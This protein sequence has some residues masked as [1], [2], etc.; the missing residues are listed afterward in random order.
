MRYNDFEHLAL[1]HG[2]T[3]AVGEVLDV[4]KHQA[5]AKK[6]FVV[7]SGPCGGGKSSF[8]RAGV[9][10]L[11][12][13]GG[14]PVGSGPWRHA[15]TRPGAADD[16]FEALAAALVAKS[17][18]PELQ[19]AGSPDDCRTLASQLRK[20]PNSV[21]VRIARVL[22]QLT[23]QELDRLSAKPKTR[24]LLPDKV[25]GPNSSGQVK[26]KL[27]LALVVDQLE[28]AVYGTFPSARGEIY[29]GALRFS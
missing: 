21:V 20:D 9:L 24:G 28:D 18:L 13:R 23:S 12:T 5:K 1:Y 2:R 8:V 10:P 19:D 6:P 25:I 27:Q 7:V 3:R 17:A 11:L 15:I 22:G 26:P 29:H 4:L 14:T 16:P